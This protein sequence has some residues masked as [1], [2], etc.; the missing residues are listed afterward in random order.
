MLDQRRAMI[1]P[2]MHQRLVFL[3]TY[4]SHVSQQTRYFETTCI[5]VCWINVAPAS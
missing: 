3:V 1:E 4:D 2:A 5:H